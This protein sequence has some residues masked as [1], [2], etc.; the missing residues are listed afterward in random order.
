[1]N[2]D[3][4]I[5]TISSTPVIARQGMAVERH[6]RR[7]IKTFPGVSYFDQDHPV[8]HSRAFFD[9]HTRRIHSELNDGYSLLCEPKKDRLYLQLPKLSSEAHLARCLEPFPDVYLKT[10]NGGRYE[11]DILFEYDDQ[12]V[13]GEVKSTAIVSR[14]CVKRRFYGPRL[15]AFSKFFSKPVTYWAIVSNDFTPGEP[16]AFREDGHTLVHLGPSNTLQK[17]KNSEKK[18]EM[19]L[20]LLALE[21]NWLTK[22]EPPRGG[23]GDYGRHK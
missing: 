3:D 16:S 22:I 19:T 7:L 21:R 13:F 1:M 9:I 23:W 20:P 5:D 15:A 10:R 11:I 17:K 14:H 12:V 8:F 6:A 18:P 4:L 2:L